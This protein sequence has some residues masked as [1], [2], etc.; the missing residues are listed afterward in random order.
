MK[1]SRLTRKTWMPPGK[2]LERKS[3][4]VSHSSLGRACPRPSGPKPKSSLRSAPKS[5]T[6]AER[7]VHDLVLKTRS[8]GVCEFQLPGICEYW[9]TDFCH[10]CAAGRGGKYVASNG[11]AGCRFCHLAT[12]NTN[13]LREYYESL[14][15][16]C[17][18]GAITT[19]VPVVLHCR[20][21]VLLGDDGS[22]TDLDM[23]GG[24]Q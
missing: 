13:G 11:M 14:G 24:F 6:A 15:F 5:L 12:T 4:L 22:I 9:A 23:P 10:R 16:I 1:N 7:R 21:P 19:E 17:R 18:T 8:G 3:E 2:P 20:R